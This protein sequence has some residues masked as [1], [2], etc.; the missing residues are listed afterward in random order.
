MPTFMG[1]ESRRSAGNPQI[2]LHRAPR[3]QSAKKTCR[4]PADE[5]GS[6]SLRPVSSLPSILQART[7]RSGADAA[8]SKDFVGGR[9]LGNAQRLENWKRLRAPGWPA[10]LRSRSEEHTSELQSL[11]H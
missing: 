8:A 6:L 5:S 4:S 2:I 9:R 3:L 1:M 10:F 7:R 11:R